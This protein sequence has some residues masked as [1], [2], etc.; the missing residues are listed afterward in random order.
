M[1]RHG[2]ALLTTLWLVTAASVLT[3]AGVLAARLG[4]AKAR[5]RI[6]LTRAAWARESCLEMVRSA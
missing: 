4:V 5:N 6:L 2:F 1:N 3:A